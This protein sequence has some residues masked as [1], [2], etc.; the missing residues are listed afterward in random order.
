M[1]P[2]DFNLYVARQP[3]LSSL[4][5][6]QTL[7][8]NTTA[9][10]NIS[11][12]IAPMIIPAMAPP[13]RSREP[14]LATPSSLGIPTVPLESGRDELEGE[15]GC[16]DIDVSVDAQLADTLPNICGSSTTL[17]LSYSNFSILHNTIA[18][19]LLCLC[20]VSSVLFARGFRF[21]RS[22]VNSLYYILRRYSNRY[23]VACESF[24]KAPYI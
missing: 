19:Y 2:S 14:V 9:S 6:G 16:T 12:A 10:N 18:H 5:S 17:R 15:K 11:P 23:T 13:A 22:L 1:A 4:S 3:D 7:A 21:G 20:R 8:R 24:F